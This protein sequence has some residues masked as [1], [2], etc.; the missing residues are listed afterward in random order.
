MLN[1][2]KELLNIHEPSVK[3]KKEI[4]KRKLKRAYT[5]YGSRVSEFSCGANLA[6]HISLDVAQG[7]R[8]VNDILDELAKIDPD[9]PKDRMPL[10][11]N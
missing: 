5:S 6:A 2:I 10:G 7:A 9:T 11:S 3:I 4:L 8:K 1:K